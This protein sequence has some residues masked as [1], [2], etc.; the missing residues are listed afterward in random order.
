MTSATRERVEYSYLLGI[1][2]LRPALALLAYAFGFHQISDD[3]YSRT[4][5]SE[6]FAHAP[7]LDPSGTSWLPFPFWVTGLA[8][9][10]FGRSI[11]T[12]NIV[13]VVLSSAA[14]LAF[15]LGMRRDGVR[16]TTAA[17]AV[18][19]ASLSPWNVWCSAAPV[20]EGFVPPIL[21][22]AAFEI[23]RNR[24][25]GSTAALVL[26][27]CL[28]RYEAWPVAAVFAW[29]ALGNR[30]WKSLLLA[31]LG[32]LAW[33]GW[34]YTSHGDA[35]HF[36]ARVTR[37]K[38]GLGEAPESIL[39]AL[40]RYPESLWREAP[41]LVTL[42]ALATIIAAFGGI[43]RDTAPIV[44]SRAL[45]L[46]LV[47]VA[48]YAFLAYG[49]IR[50]GAPTHHAERAFLT[51]LWVLALPL[52]ESAVSLWHYDNTSTRW[53]A[54]LLVLPLAFV[55]YD[56]AQLR[57]PPGNAAA[58]TREA[59]LLR[60][61]E[62]RDSNPTHVAL[63]PCAYEHFALIAAFGSPERVEIARPEP[64]ATTTPMNRAATDCPR[65]TATP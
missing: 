43:R 61:K 46:V 52:A 15:Y 7:Q 33:I 37:Y 26:A 60:G 35:F 47:L 55:L 36:F 29:S 63:V 12:A 23:S 4:V 14:T 59:Q 19:L 34:N 57:M 25:T 41:V 54:R 51:V 40:L 64:S 6:T 10:L 24:T 22:L 16:H 50:G 38:A 21:A 48:L 1:A 39:G 32:P 30:T 11:A 53:R 56:L 13:G 2:L 20:P 65:V 49:E 5:I 9:M 31:A 8:M 58:E 45:R 18:V 42:G 62:L 17:L 44:R 27:A 28:S 3:D